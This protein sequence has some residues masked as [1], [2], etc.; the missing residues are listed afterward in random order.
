MREEVSGGG[1]LRCRAWTWDE[2]VGMFIRH[3]LG[4]GDSGKIGGFLG[5]GKERAFTTEG[6][7]VHRGRRKF[8]VDRAHEASFA[9]PDSRGRLSYIGRFGR[10]GPTRA[11]DEGRGAGT[12]DALLGW[13][14]LRG[15]VSEQS[16]T[17]AG[18][19]K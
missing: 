5:S 15:E 4:V 1:R 11:E 16:A 18:V 12:S 9:R 17:F 6:T 14:F 10:S 8:L 19:G 3:R 7:E 2:A 13:A